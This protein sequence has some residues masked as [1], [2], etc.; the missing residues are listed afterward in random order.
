M[1]NDTKRIIQHYDPMCITLFLYN[2]YTKLKHE[3]SRV[4]RFLTVKGNTI[5]VIIF[6]DMY[7]CEILISDME[8]SMKILSI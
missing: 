2:W 5:F 7:I 4:K 6:Y 1:Q 8:N 3:T